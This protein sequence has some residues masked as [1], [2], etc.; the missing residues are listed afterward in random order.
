MGKDRNGKEIGKG[1]TQRPNG[2]YIGR[3]VNTYICINIQKIRIFIH[4]LNFKPFSVIE[5]SSAFICK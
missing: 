4:F 3:F 1:I 2:Q 5:L